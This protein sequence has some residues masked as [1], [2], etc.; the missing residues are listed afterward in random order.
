MYDCA[1]CGETIELSNDI[2]DKNDLGNYHPE[3]LPLSEWSREDLS[4]FSEWTIEE[5]C[6]LLKAIKE[7][8]SENA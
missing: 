2:Y 5:Q 4:L 6:D 1:K 8:E 7:K 3:C